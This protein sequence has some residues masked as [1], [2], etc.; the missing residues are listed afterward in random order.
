M[1]VGLGRRIG[2][3]W[4]VVLDG[5]GGWRWVGAE[6]WGG[7]DGCGAFRLVFGGWALIW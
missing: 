4:E 6:A 7:V 1:R 5:S 3:G 2:P